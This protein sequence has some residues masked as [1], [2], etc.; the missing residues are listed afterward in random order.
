MILSAPYRASFG[1]LFLSEL[2]LS[3]KLNGKGQALSVI[4]VKR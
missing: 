4:Q 3:M 2:L 1:F